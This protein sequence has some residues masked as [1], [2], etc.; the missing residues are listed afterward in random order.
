MLDIETGYEGK[1]DFPARSSPPEV[2]YML[3][4][5]AAH[6]QQLFRT[7]VCGAPAAWARRSNT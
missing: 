5:V 2:N 7:H 4:T 6:G 3:A 1:F